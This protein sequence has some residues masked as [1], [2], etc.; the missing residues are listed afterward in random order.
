[1]NSFLTDISTDPVSLRRSVPTVAQTHVPAIRKTAEIGLGASPN[2][3]GFVTMLSQYHASGGLARGD[4]LGRL[5]DDWQCGD[6]VSLARLISADEIF[7]FRW[8]GECWI[9]MFQFE[10]RDLSVKPG[11]RR[12]LAELM[13][14]FDDWQLAVWFVR[15]NPWLQ[16]KRPLDLLDSDLTGVLEV[17][18]ADRFIVDG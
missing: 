13:Q 17:A 6:H 15:P 5:L 4:T 12:V 2:S 7:S 3:R 8:R 14:V 16:T 10:L 18:R 9:P 11:P 1:M